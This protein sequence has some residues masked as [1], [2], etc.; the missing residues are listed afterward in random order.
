MKKHFD[1]QRVDSLRMEIKANHHAEVDEI[2][3]KVKEITAITGL[4]YY[5]GWNIYYKEWQCGAI[6][7]KPSPSYLKYLAPL[8]KVYPDGRVALKVRSKWERI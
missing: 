2:L 8:R 4:I 7:S 1:H 5:F 6:A 3:S